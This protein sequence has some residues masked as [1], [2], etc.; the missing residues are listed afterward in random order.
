MNFKNLSVSKKLVGVFALVLAVTIGLGLFAQTSL[1][2]VNDVAADVSGN[3]LP[4]VKALGQYEYAVTRLRAAQSTYLLPLA[5]ETRARLIKNIQVYRNQADTAWTKYKPLVTTGTEQNLADKI[6]A[7]R[8][9]YESSLTKNLEI[10]K[11][12]GDRAA[13]TFAQGESRDKFN[14]L[15]EAIDADVQFND[16]MSAQRGAEGQSVFGTAR[17]WIYIALGLAAVFCGAAGYAL[18]RAISA[19]LTNMTEAMG[20]LARGNLN[21]HVPHADQMDEIGKLA[22][23]MTTFK[24]QLAAAE[25]AK[26]KQ[27]QVIVSSIGTGLDHLAKGDLTHRVTDDLTGAFAKLKEDFNLAMTRLQETVK[28]VLNSTHQIDNNASEISTAADDLSRRTEQQ[29]A[30]LEETAA[31]L[32]EITATVKKTAANAKEASHS[33][34]GAKDAAENGGRVVETAVRAM[35]SIAQSSK[36]ITDIIGVIDEIA[37]QTNLL[38]LNA[39]VEAARAGEAGKGFAVVASEVRALAQRSSEAAKQIKALIN[40][41]SE[42]VGD[43]V[44]YV[45]ETGQALKRIVDQV[46][47]INALVGEM[48]QAAEQQSTGI[49][50]VN[51]AVGQMDQVTQQNAAMVEES[52]AAARNMAGETKTLT[53]LIGFFSVGDTHFA[54]PAAAAPR[55]TARSLPPRP[56]PKPV[57]RPAAKMAAAG[58]GKP[59]AAPTGDDDWTEF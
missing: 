44:K 4:S 42:H 7:A 57:A 53:E 45:G 52:T 43:G 17:L 26:E 1:S 28:N 21:A 23:A 37:F 29:A 59:A 3:W 12:E 30:S 38:A 51:S 2:K 24:N 19:P 56:A 5:D 11:T 27:T 10:F 47:Q 6:V 35:D 18:V 34:A 58:G 13:T 49:E 9:A 25:E 46:V 41:S 20:E 16:Q 14:A 40:T 15:V 55:Q 54:A 39:G 22:E 8:E 36:Q 31:A 32:E 50:Q 33:V 48:A